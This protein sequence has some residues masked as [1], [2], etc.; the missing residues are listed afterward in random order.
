MEDHSPTLSICELYRESN[1]IYKKLVT[2]I[3]KNLLS[4]RNREIKNISS[5][6]LDE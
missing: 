1:F 5:S 3:E 6:L 2:Y 4:Q